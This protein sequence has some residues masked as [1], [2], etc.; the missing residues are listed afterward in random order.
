MSEVPKVIRI[1]LE[2][3]ADGGLRV[4][5]EDVRGL[6]LSHSDPKKV[7]EDVLPALDTLWPP[8]P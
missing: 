8:K 2:R 6:V 7:I 4:W 3:R 1:S 5:S